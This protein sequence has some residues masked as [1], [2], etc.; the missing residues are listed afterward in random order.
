MAFDFAKLLFCSQSSRT[1]PALLMVTPLSN[2]SRCG[3]LTRL[4][5]PTLVEWGF[6]DAVPAPFDP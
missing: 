1:S 5:S 4:W 2:S 3:T 6:A